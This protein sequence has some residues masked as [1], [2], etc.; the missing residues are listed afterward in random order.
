M[1]PNHQL[2]QKSSYCRQCLLAMCLLTAAS[3]SYAQT[4][5]VELSQQMLDSSIRFLSSLDA[6]QAK[7]AQFAFEDEERLN[8]HFIPRARNGIPLKDLTQAQRENAMAL[9]QTFLSAKGFAKSESI[10]GLE[11]VLAA[12]EQN[13]RFVRDPELYY[14]TVFGN[15]T[16]NGDWAMRYEGHHQAFNWTFSGGVGI[17]STPQFF[18]SNPAEVREG[19]QQGLRVL[20]AEEDLARELVKSLSA[21]QLAIALLTGTAP[22]DIFTAAEKEV[23][24]L[25]PEGIRY[26]ALNQQQQQLLLQLIAEVASTQSEILAAQRMEQIAAA[27]NDSILFAWIGGLEKGDPHYYR[28]QGAG[29]LI[30]YDNTQ[31]DANHV[32]LVWRDFT[33]DFGRDLIR[34]HYGTVA[35]EHG[36][37]HQH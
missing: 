34:M 24:P 1:R 2:Q 31:N 20:A 10:R 37:G 26:D 23:A 27:G 5:T 8:W 28:V 4:T 22:N 11:N 29:F 25:K 35:A 36:A 18:G 9:L 15:P 13:G 19:P 7:L 33:G 3:V 16:L 32:H 6:E 21:D 17:A 30:E 14:L 12:I